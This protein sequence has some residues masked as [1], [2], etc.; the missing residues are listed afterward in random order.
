MA[1]KISRTATALGAAVLLALTACGGGGSTTTETPE[2]SP[3]A[4]EAAPA[5]TTQG[6]DFTENTGTSSNKKLQAFAVAQ[7]ES[8]DCSSSTD[9]AEQLATL[10]D[11]ASFKQEVS[12][13][14]WS[15]NSGEA[16][17]A[18]TVTIV[19]VEKR[20]GCTISA[21]DSP[22]RGKTVDCQDL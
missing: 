4:S 21:I 15:S 16:L 10:I 22:S 18:V 5:D 12:D 7:Y 3:T 1:M 17:G 9:V 2:A 19:D 13:Q 14:G 8:L 11:S 6:C 20:T